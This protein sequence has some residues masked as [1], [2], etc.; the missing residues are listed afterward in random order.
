MLLGLVNLKLANGSRN[1]VNQ[2]PTFY[3]SLVHAG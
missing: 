3:A 1:L 2:K